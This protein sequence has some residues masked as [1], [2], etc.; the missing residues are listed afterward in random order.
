MFFE[1]D[2]T[3]KSLYKK[4]GSENA[5]IKILEKEI[6]LVQPNF[7]LL[8]GSPAYR[9]IQYFTE[10]RG[11][12]SISVNNEIL[13]QVQD[14]RVIPVF[15]MIHLSGAANGA[16]TPYIEANKMTDFRGKFSDVEILAKIVCSKIAENVR[17][18]N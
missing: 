8:M 10:N 7:I 4:G 9:I 5:N 13:R 16:R 6:K 17:S 2:K 14:N 12:K 11:T 3:T 1:A 18:K 15:G